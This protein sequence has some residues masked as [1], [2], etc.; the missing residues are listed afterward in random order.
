ML[1]E[2]ITDVYGP[3]TEKHWDYVQE[4]LEKAINYYTDFILPSA[5]FPSSPRR[6]TNWWTNSFRA[7]CPGK[8]MSRPYKTRPIRIA[9]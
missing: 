9:R 6:K 5:A 4:L 7:D 8:K 1:R 2:F 3:E